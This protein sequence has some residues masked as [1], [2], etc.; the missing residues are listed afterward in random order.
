MLKPNKF[1]IKINDESLSATLQRHYG[2]FYN[3]VSDAMDYVWKEASEGDTVEI[4]D[5]GGNVYVVTGQ[6]S[7]ET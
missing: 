2:S 5:Q 1:Y 6:G 7:S 3:S 4:I